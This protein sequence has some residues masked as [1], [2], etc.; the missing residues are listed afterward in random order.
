MTI[1]E[2]AYK[3]YV[4]C[5]VI[6]TAGRD[7][8]L[9]SNICAGQLPLLNPLL[10]HNEPFSKHARACTVCPVGIKVW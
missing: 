8:N 1:V 9:R 2:M 3:P 4:R 5:E 10:N 7:A 6:I